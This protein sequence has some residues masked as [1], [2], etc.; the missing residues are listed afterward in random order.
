VDQKEKNM[1]RTAKI[2]AAATLMV[3]FS[4]SAALAALPVLTG[5]NGDD[6]LKGT[7]KAE[8]IRGLR[9]EDEIVD[10]LNKDLI[11][12]G[13][14]SDNLIGY[15]GD[16]SVD[17]FDGGAGDDIIQSRDIPASKDRVWCGP[18]VDRVYADE[19]DV[20]SG[21]CERVRAW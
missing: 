3:V 17:H 16:T 4:A 12:G 14:G 18:G 1:G 9:G 5:T 19:A 7:K 13:N 21:H 6:Q 20:V 8:E 11:Y 15:G 2:L 10:G